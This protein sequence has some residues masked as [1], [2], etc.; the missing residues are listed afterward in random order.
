MFPYLKGRQQQV[1]GSAPLLQPFHEMPVPSALIMKTLRQGCLVLDMYSAEYTRL[2]PAGHFGVA[3]VIATK[4]GEGRNCDL[5]VT[6]LVMSHRL[7]K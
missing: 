1:E 5:P 2:F 4:Q 7:G 3:A 6:R